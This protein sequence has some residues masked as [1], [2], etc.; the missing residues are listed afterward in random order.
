MSWQCSVTPVKTASFPSSKWKSAVILDIDV[1]ILV[2]WS[3]KRKFFN[4][5]FLPIYINGVDRKYVKLTKQELTFLVWLGY[6]CSHVC[7]GGPGALTG[8]HW[9]LE[10]GKLWERCHPSHSQPPTERAG[11]EERN[12]RPEP[13]FPLVA[14]WPPGI[15]AIMRLLNKQSLIPTPGTWHGH[16][17]QWY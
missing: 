3:C 10:P 4:R 12:R 14:R 1:T 15:I 2:I 7:W 16:W 6:F 9:S 11:E 17:R 8:C 5:L 13:V